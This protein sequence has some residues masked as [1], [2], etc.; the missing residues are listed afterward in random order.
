[1]TFLIQFSIG[2][3][4]VGAMIAGLVLLG[5]VVPVVLIAAAIVNVNHYVALLYTLFPLT[6]IFLF[7]MLGSLFLVEGYFATYRIAKWLYSKIPGIT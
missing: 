4:L 6:I 2:I 7:L 1:M 5:N 3:A